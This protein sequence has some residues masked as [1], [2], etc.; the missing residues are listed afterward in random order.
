MDLRNITPPQYEKT[1]D[2]EIWAGA[3]SI[4]NTLKIRHK[5]QAKILSEK[6]T[7]VNWTALKGTP[8]GLLFVF[9]WLGYRTLTDREGDGVENVEMRGSL[10]GRRRAAMIWGL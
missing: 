4:K 2:W 9:S 6:L 3:V 10:R 5:M 1:P 7:A 8:S